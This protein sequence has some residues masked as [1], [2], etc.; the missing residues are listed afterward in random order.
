MSSAALLYRGIV[1]RPAIGGLLDPGLRQL[2]TR[3]DLNSTW[4]DT[5]R[6]LV[7]GSAFQP[8]A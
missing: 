5:H 2:D 6:I 8:I 7:S 3:R 1:D 4:S